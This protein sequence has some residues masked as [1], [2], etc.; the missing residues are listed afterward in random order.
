LETFLAEWRGW[1]AV[2]VSTLNIKITDR[3]KNYFYGEIAFM[4]II[5][6]I[7]ARYAATRF[8]A[9]LMQMLGDKT[10]IRHTYDNT[11]ATKLFDEVVVVTDSETIYREITGHGGKAKMSRNAHESGTDRIAE[12]IGDMDAEDTDIVVNVQGDEPFVQTRPLQQLLALFEGEQGRQ[13]RVG[14]LVQVLKEQRFIDDPN[15]VKVALDRK[16][17]ALFFSRSV[18]PYPRNKEAAPTHYEHIGIYAFR[19]EALLAFTSWPVTP[20]EA[21]EKI[22]C[23]RF[24]EYGVPIR[25]AITEYM[26]VEI[27]TPADLERAAGLLVKGLR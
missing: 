5:A 25:M 23:L 7:P 11:L 24:L 15:Y 16:G 21:A 9:K 27:D 8:P 2:I 3:L 18:I 19:R 13:L 17:N 22:E 14:S 1:Q 10:V 26:G 4:K 20:L 6:M 12:A